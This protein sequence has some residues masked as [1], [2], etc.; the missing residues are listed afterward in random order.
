MIYRDGYK[1][2]LTTLDFSIE[3]VILFDPTRKPQSNGNLESDIQDAKLLYYHPPDKHIDIKRNMVGLIEGT[4]IFFSPFSPK[5]QAQKVTLIN[6]DNH[7]YISKNVEGSLWLCIGINNHFSSSSYRAATNSNSYIS[8]TVF[9]VERPSI[10][11]NLAV[12]FI[13]HFVDFFT[14]FYGPIRSHINETGVHETFQ[15]IFEGFIQHYKRLNAKPESHLDLLKY[16][17]K[18]LNYAPTD[19]KTF[20]L[21]HYLTNVLTSVFDG[22]CHFALFHKGYYIYTTL[23]QDV[24][25]LFYDYLYI[26]NSISEI[27]PGKV[28]SQFSRMNAFTSYGHCNFFKQGRG[29]LYGLIDEDLQ[30]EELAQPVEEEKKVQT[31]KREIVSEDYDIYIPDVWIKE[32]KEVVKYKFILYDNF[33]T[34]MLLF[35]DQKKELSPQKLQQIKLMLN[36]ETF[37]LATELD[38]QVGKLNP[39][40]EMTQLTY[41]N[42]LSLSYRTSLSYLKCN[43]VLSSKIIFESIGKFLANQRKEKELQMIVFRLNM[44]WVIIKYFNGRIVVLC[45]NSQLAIQKVEEEKHRLLESFSSSI[46]L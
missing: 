33:G 13:D 15:L 10:D 40:E 32:G 7:S 42:T 28:E 20:L 29:F 30:I 41:Y 46:L 26:S 4:T 8:D 22:A 36:R 38:K 16:Q 21:I 12:K 35:Y 19:K 43:D 2:K 11:L 1:P 39:K 25:Q 9:Q 18:P 3:S 37:A 31:E 24:T 45:L 44:N 6:L 5:K 14:L 17:I 34:R 23:D 27:D